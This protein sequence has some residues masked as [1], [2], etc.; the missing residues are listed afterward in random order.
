ML[1]RDST[2]KLGLRNLSK[3]QKEKIVSEIMKQGT[4]F[5]RLRINVEKLGRNSAFTGFT[6]NLSEA[7]MFSFGFIIGWIVCTLLCQRVPEQDL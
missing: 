6:F 3:E 1:S 5:Q 4:Y 2:G 7:L